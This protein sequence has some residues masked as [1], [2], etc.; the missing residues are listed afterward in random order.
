MLTIY[1]LKLNSSIS[2]Y[3]NRSRLI[4]KQEYDNKIKS[5]IKDSISK[6]LDLNENSDYSEFLITLHGMVTAGIPIPPKYFIPSF[7]LKAM[8]QEYYK[9]N[10]NIV[11]QLAQKVLENNSKFDSQI[12][13]E[14]R[15]WLCLAYCRMK[16]SNFF[17]EIS[18]FREEKDDGKKD[19]FFLL[20][21]YYRNM[22][23]NEEAEENFHNVLDIDP[24][25][26]RS[27]RELVIVYL[28]MNEYA[29]ALD[30]ARDYYRFKTN[31]LHIQAY[32]TCLIKKKDKTDD[33]L[34]TISELLDN[35]KKSL[36]SRAQDIFNEMLAEYNYYIEGNATKAISMLLHSLELS[37]NNNFTFK[38]LMEIYRLKGMGHEI[39]NL[40]LSYP[41][42]IELDPDSD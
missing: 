36:D 38:A 12:I 13:R 16:D 42:L 17:N 28:R 24:N 34:I 21:F 41:N 5:I 27:K 4:L 7:I 39:D 32:F 40:L 31:V 1:N 19:Y 9:R 26:S 15:Y 23:R 3:I 8:I 6:P 20:G 33:D 2:D 29:K 25:H 14:T 11:I 18:Y 30:W 10:Y 37:P 35:T 22:N